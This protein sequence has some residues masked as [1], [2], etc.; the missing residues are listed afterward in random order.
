VH[1][2]VFAFVIDDKPETFFRVKPLH[3]ASKHGILRD[4]SSGAFASLQ[5]T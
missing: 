1:K 3:R 2:H 5:K 4:L